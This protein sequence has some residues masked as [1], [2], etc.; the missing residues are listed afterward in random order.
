M[1]KGEGG[2][3]GKKQAMGITVAHNL[4]PE[5]LDNNN[6][7]YGFGL[8][9]VAGLA[10]AL[11]IRWGKSFVKKFLFSVSDEDSKAIDPKEA[12]NM[13]VKSLTDGSIGLSQARYIAKNI[14]E[15]LAKL[16]PAA[17]MDKTKEIVESLKGKFNEAVKAL[18]KE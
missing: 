4:A 14:P 16:T 9:C 1:A 10:A 3:G 7:L 17:E 18:P 8:M 5:S 13:T 6:S 11:T 2:D 12:V 15:A